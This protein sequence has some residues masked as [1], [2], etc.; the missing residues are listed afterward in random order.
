MLLFRKVILCPSPSKAEAGG[1]PVWDQYGIG[2]IRKPWFL[3]FLKGKKK[4]SL[5][6]NCAEPITTHTKDGDS[7]LPKINPVTST[8]IC[9]SG[10]EEGTEKMICTKD[11]DGILKH[12]FTWQSLPVLCMRDKQKSFLLG[13]AVPTCAQH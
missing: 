9:F 12:S 10:F 4:V 6:P 1:P 11:Q 3:L 13:M 5:K 8:K 7:L 2:Y